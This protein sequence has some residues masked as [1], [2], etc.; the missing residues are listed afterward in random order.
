MIPELSRQLN[1][2]ALL[3]VSGILAYAFA[4]Q[5]LFADLPCPLCLLQRVGFTV[6][7][8][9]FALNVAC[10]ARPSHYGLAIIGAVAGAAVSIRQILLHIVPD[11]GSFGE[12]LLGIHFYTWALIAFTMIV[13][14]SA[15][16]LLFDKQFDA[17]SIAM[18]RGERQRVSRLGAVALASFGALV[19]MNAG[20]TFAE[21]GLGL[22]PDDP[23][24]YQ[25][26]GESR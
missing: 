1:A 22:C 4:D 26:L 25:L 13:L 7:A 17:P 2:L 6:A 16:L 8:F 5:F 18:E 9:G 15:A 21:C 3:G 24:R 11:T 23:A 10:G 12:A 19:L 20:S 14:G